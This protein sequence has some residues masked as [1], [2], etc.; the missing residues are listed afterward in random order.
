MARRH[1]LEEQ[2]IRHRL[3]LK[4]ERGTAG[5]DGVPKRLG[6]AGESVSWRRPPR[7]NLS[8]RPV[9]TRSWNAGEPTADL[10]DETFR[11]WLTRTGI[12]WAIAV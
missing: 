12:G 6:C 11:H 2:V 7:L 5:C 8:P 3:P 1:L 10:T 4:E 9:P